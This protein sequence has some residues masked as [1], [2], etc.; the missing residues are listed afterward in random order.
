MVSP[1]PDP[2]ESRR[3]C[4]ETERD[5]DDLFWRILFPELED[6]RIFFLELEDPDT[7]VGEVEREADLEVLN[8]PNLDLEMEAELDLDLV[9]LAG[10]LAG[11]EDFDLERDI[12]LDSC[13]DLDRDMDFDLDLER[14]LDLD[15]ERDLD[16]DLDRDLE[17]ICWGL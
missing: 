6:S 10:D 12:D 4:G 13:L 14:D 5:E 11:D 9:D 2:P 15:L 17:T 16:L 7:G 3:P 1:S 8:R